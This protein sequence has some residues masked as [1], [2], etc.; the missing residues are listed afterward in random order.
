M[1]GWIGRGHLLERKR[2]YYDEIQSFASAARVVHIVIGPSMLGHF[3][4]LN[5]GDSPTK[6]ITPEI[7]LPLLN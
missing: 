4:G 1:G 5:I 7:L 2:V 6:I 3:I